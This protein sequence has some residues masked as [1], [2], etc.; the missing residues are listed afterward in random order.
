MDFE[1]KDTTIRCMKWSV[2]AKSGTSL[3]LV[4]RSKI[5]MTLPIRQRHPSRH[6]VFRGEKGKTNPITEFNSH[7]SP[8]I[9]PTVVSPLKLRQLS[10]ISRLNFFPATSAVNRISSVPAAYQ[11][12]CNSTIC[13]KI[14]SGGSSV[15]APGRGGRCRRAMAVVANVYRRRGR[16]S[17][18]H[19]RVVKCGV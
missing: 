7:T 18:E 19:L 12:V 13:V 17:W 14:L 11:I 4:T 2:R 8:N 1:Y 9:H 3:L 10:T 16:L 6:D 15:R 5:E